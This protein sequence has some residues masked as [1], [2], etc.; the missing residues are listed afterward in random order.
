[1]ALCVLRRGDEILVFEG[2]DPSVP[3]RFY[4]PFGGG[5]EYG[6]LSR[7]AVRREMREELG[8]E[9]LEP[10][11]I[12]TLENIFEYGGEPQH[13]ICFIYEAEPADP[14]FLEL[15]SP[16]ATEANGER[17]VSSWRPLS[18]L[19][20]GPSPLYPTGLPELLAARV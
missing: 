9:L 10:R 16:P 17:L 6:E 3:E 1:V 18:E 5:V 20:E 12:A 19:L 14:A 4:R 15:D 11:L 2:C 13:E 8:I 7:D